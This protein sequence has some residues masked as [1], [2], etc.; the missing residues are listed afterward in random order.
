MT[1]EAVLA[2]TGSVCKMQCCLRPQ[3]L[4]PRGAKGASS[5]QT[6]VVWLK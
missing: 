2:F 1:T 5:S 3:R 6:A 4:G